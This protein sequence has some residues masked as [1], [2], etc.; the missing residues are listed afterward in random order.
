MRR[1]ESTH[2]AG[3]L[4]LRQV[5]RALGVTRW[6]ARKLMAR[7]RGVARPEGSP[8]T[9]DARVCDYIRVLHQRDTRALQPADDDWLTRYLE[10]R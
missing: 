9:Y 7:H 4:T 1:P 3:R 5:A 6:Q 2:A 10:G 8:P